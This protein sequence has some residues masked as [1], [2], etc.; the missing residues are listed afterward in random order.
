MPFSRDLLSRR[1]LLLR[2]LAAIS[3]LLSIIA[4]TA[5]AQDAGKPVQI[6]SGDSLVRLNVLVTD[7]SNRAVT[8][9]RHEEFKVLEDGKPQPLT[10]FAREE[11]PASYGLLMDSSGSMRILLDHIINAGKGVVAGNKRGD[12]TFI[13]RFTDAKNIQLEQGFTSNRYALEESLDNIFVEGGL[14]A[15]IDAIDRAVDYLKKNQKTEAPR[16]RRQAIVLISDGEDRSSRALTPE[17]LLNR[18]REEEVQ[19]FIIGLSKLSSLQS[20][21]EKAAS[22][23]T[24]IAEATGGRVF[25]PK[26]VSEIPGIVDEITRDLHTQYTLGY[27]STNPIPDGSYRKVQVTVPDSPTRKKLNVITRP[28]YVARQTG[29]G[30]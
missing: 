11:L 30:H 25:F 4:A 8:D 22:F 12:E 26:S 5:T 6:K 21:R 15:V 3:F 29:G 23:L 20:S 16:Q 27:V 19:F 1:K 14:T 17:A 13:M 10:Y 9:L 28:G 24:R 2:R 18:L 7:S